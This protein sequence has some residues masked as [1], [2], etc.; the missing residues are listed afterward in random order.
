[1][2]ILKKREPILNKLKQKDLK[3]LHKLYEIYKSD[4]EK[5]K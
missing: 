5:K 2:W 1:M 4:E 3:K